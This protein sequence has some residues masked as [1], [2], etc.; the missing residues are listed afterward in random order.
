MLVKNQLRKKANYIF[1]LEFIL[2][3]FGPHLRVSV[4]RGSIVVMTVAY[5]PTDSGI[6][7][8]LVYYV[9]AAFS[10]P[11]NF[12]SYLLPTFIISAIFTKPGSPQNTPYVLR[13]EIIFT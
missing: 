8:L 7:S 13:C 2:T 1:G 12:C 3:I 4:I 9:V 10:K 6:M 5:R 11:L